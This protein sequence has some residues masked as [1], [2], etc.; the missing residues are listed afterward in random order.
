DVRLND[1]M[2]VELQ[3]K[4]RTDQINGW[5][6]HIPAVYLGIAQAARDYAVRFANDYTPNSLKWPIKEV[7][8]VQRHIGE[9]DLE[10]MKARHFLY[11]VAE[12]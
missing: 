11:H 6:L 5:L 12:L 9:M 8:A 1:S 7:P 4:K 10:L 3:M 2:L